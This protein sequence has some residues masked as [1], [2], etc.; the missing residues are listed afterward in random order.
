V[1]ITRPFLSVIG[2]DT[3][4][5]VIIGKNGRYQ[6]TCLL[7]IPLHK[8][9]VQFR[10]L[11]N[12]L[13][14]LVYLFVPTLIADSDISRLGR[15]LRVQAEWNVD[16]SSGGRVPFANAGPDTDFWVEAVLCALPIGGPAFL[17]GKL[18][19]C[20]HCLGLSFSFASG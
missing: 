7:A 14:E 10:P 4:K 20:K 8:V 13:L 1:A 11:T 2:Q 9:E 6:M 17:E 18:S 3:L 5:R 12:H 16:G 19:V 15:N